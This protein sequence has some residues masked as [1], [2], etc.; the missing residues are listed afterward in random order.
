MTTAAPFPA[1]PKLITFDTYGT[2]ID[3]DSALRDHLRSLFDARGVG[4][5]V[6]AFYTEWYYSYALPTLSA[7][8]MLY[9]DLLRTTMRRAL[10]AAGVSVE[11]SELAALGDVMAA[12]EPFPDTVEVLTELRRH[13][14]LATIS[15]SQRDILESSARRMGD[16]FTHQITGEVVGA[17]KPARPLFDLVLERAGVRPEET[18]HIAQSQYV[19]LPRSVPMGIATIWINRQGQTLLPEHPAPT[20]ELPDLRDV[21]RVLGFVGAADGG[22]AR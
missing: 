22:S 2:L 17:Y 5:D 11:E 20:L 15:N 13:V 19:D 14:P 10:A 3:W 4:L 12:A 7:D 21:P 1:R 8:F 16:P 6:A 9:R 18:V